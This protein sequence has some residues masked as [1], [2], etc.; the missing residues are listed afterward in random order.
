MPSD[1]E[2]LSMPFVFVSDEAFALS[3]HM[4]RQYP[5]KNLTYLKRVYSYSLSRER[6]IVECT[7]G[8]LANK[9]RIH[10]RPVDLKQ[11]FVT[12]S[13]KLIVFYTFMYGKM[14]EFLFDESLYEY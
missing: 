7:F 4:L 9:W 2:G 1:A 10:H 8:S 6:R 11:I 14:I 12:A 5:N 3:E 13:L